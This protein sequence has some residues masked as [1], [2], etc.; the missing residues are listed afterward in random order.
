MPDAYS[1]R[2]ILAFPEGQYW[3]LSAC[4]YA[5]TEPLWTDREISIA[6]HIRVFYHFRTQQPKR[7]GDL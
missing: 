2:S 3:L 4:F 7:R 5:D 1:T 6:A